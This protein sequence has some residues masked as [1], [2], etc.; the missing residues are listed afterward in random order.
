MFDPLTY[1]CDVDSSSPSHASLVKEVCRAYIKETEAN[2]GEDIEDLKYI[3]DTKVSRPFHKY[4]L[5]E[6]YRR[7]FPVKNIK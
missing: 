1:F 4:S 7:I 6:K 5:M 3:E 2:G